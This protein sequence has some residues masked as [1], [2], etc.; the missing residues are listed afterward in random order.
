MC[1]TNQMEIPISERS[2]ID[3]VAELMAHIQKRFECSPLDASGIVKQYIDTLIS[4]VDHAGRHKRN[5]VVNP[6]L[7]YATRRLLQNR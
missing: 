1:S 6:V 4:C 2:E 5:S 3:V 7:H